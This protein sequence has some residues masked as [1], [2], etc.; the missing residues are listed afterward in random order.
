MRDAFLSDDRDQALAD[1][2]WGPAAWVS[3]SV[4]EV[5]V[6]SGPTARNGTVAAVCPVPSLITRLASHLVIL[7]WTLILGQASTSDCLAAPEEAS[8]LEGPVRAATALRPTPSRP[9]AKLVRIR[10]YRGTNVAAHFPKPRTN[11]TDDDAASDDPN[12]DDDNWDD[13]SAD[14]NTDVPVI[15]WLLEMVRYLDD[16]EVGYAPASTQPSSSPFPTLQRLRC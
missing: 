14:D 10:P 9:V 5:P 4:A 1:P 11:D 3:S 16:L 15:A 6:A 8:T 7:V 12:D 13:L 2:D